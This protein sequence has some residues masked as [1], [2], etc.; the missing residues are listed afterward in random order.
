MKKVPI[1]DVDI[2]LLTQAD[3]AVLENV[4]PDVFDNPVEPHW[5]AEF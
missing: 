5:C 3:A 4:A 1:N 2:R